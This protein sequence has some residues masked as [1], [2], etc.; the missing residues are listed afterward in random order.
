MV[1]EKSNCFIPRRQRQS[2]AISSELEETQSQPYEPGSAGRPV[3]AGLGTQAL[4]RPV[5]CLWLQEPPGLGVLSAPQH[6]RLA[7]GS[8]HTSGL[9]SMAGSRSRLRP[10]LC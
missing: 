3:R 5:P 1:S 8:P 9:P 6:S 2:Q 10:Q 4:P 7:A